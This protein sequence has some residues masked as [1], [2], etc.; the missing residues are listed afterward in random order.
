MKDVYL[1]IGSNRGDRKKNLSLAV[2]L[3]RRRAGRIVKL[4]SVY[5]TQP[6]GFSDDV[7]FLNMAMEIDTAL[8]P[9]ELLAE[10]HAIE[11]GLGRV[12]E[13]AD[14]AGS[15]SCQAREYTSRTLD[16]DILFFGSKKVFT[17]HLMI[18]HPRLHLRKFTLIPLTE[19]APGFVHPVYGKTMTELSF[20][21]PDHGKVERISDF[22]GDTD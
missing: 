3:I 4:S 19:I 18:P 7:F 6:W 8:S 17:E 9:M 12:R 16:I 2:G 5:E 1:L 22:T 21:C 10:L 14:S 13:V 11:T 15:C 20:S